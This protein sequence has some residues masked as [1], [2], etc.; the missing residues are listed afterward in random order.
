MI[1]NHIASISKDRNLLRK[2]QRTLKLGNRKKKKEKRDT[3]MYERMF[4]SDMLCGHVIYALIEHGVRPSDEAYAHKTRGWARKIKTVFQN[5]F[6]GLIS[7][8]Q[9]I[10]I[11]NSATNERRDAKKKSGRTI[12]YSKSGGRRS[13]LRARNCKPIR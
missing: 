6:L 13:Y 10:E 1:S 9:D 8:Q 11:V 4:K 3:G 7:Q 5:S 2:P 12:I